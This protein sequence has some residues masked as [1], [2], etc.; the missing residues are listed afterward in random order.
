[1]AQRELEQSQVEVDVMDANSLKR[2]ILHVERQINS[3]QAPSAALSV[4]VTACV[5]F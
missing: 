5:R 1:M 2:L 4:R 3:N